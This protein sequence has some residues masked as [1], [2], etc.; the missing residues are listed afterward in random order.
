[1][2]LFLVKGASLPCGNYV[3][4]NWLKAYDVIIELRHNY[5]IDHLEKDG[6]MYIVPEC[7][8]TVKQKRL[9]KD[10]ERNS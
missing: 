1:M 6:S 7:I 9:K 4:C 2:N 8:A 3:I 5:W 10:S